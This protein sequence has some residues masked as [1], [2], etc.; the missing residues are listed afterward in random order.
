MYRLG[1]G[2]GLMI[3]VHTPL[4]SC[5]YG[6]NGGHGHC[7]RSAFSG[8]L[9]CSAPKYPLVALA[10]LRA[11]YQHVDP[12]GNRDTSTFCKGTW[13]WDLCLECGTNYSRQQQQRLQDCVRA[14]ADVAKQVCPGF[15]R[16]VCNIASE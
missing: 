11:A 5:Q 7:L 15:G 13:G 16:A 2:E 9:L 12:E 6:I 8:L 3:L 1:L 10:G 14:N 4:C